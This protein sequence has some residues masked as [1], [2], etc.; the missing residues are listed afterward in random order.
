ME[1]RFTAHFAGQTAVE[2]TAMQTLA[3]AGDTDAM[4]NL[5][6]LLRDRDPAAA[7]A[8]WK[9]AAAVGNTEAMVGLGLLLRD[10]DPAAGA[11]RGGSGPPPPQ[12]PDAKGT[13]SCCWPTGIPSAQATWSALGEQWSAM[14][15]SW[16][17]MTTIWTK[18]YSTLALSPVEITQKLG[19][20][21]IKRVLGG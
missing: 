11:G 4:V 21:H 7:Q 20:I 5:G 3:H 18:F 12:D 19:R 14:W 1:I 10:R 16:G 15:A 8:W 2:Q 13:L 6:L 9:R 17:R